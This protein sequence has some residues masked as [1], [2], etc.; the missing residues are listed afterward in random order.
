M[1][2][3]RV[4]ARSI[5]AEVLEAAPGDG[6]LLDRAA[7]RS[8][9]RASTRARAARVGGALELAVDPA[10]FHFFDRDTGARLAAD[11]APHAG[12]ELSASTV[13]KQRETREQVLELIETLEVGDAIPSERLLASRPR[14][15]A[16]DR[17]RRARRARPRGRT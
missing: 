9:P 14:R 1:S 10:R 13:T 15:L 17:A 16:P 8:S 12:R 3:S 11:V 2:S 4:D 6:A 5:T 7:A